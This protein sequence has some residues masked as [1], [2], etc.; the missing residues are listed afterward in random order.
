M[1][2]SPPEQGTADGGGTHAHRLTCGIDLPATLRAPAAARRAARTV[3]LAWGCTDPTTH[4]VVELVVT[5]LV[6][7]AVRYA[8]G[9]QPPRLHLE[10]G[11]E[12]L[13]AVSDGSS[14]PLVVHEFT[15]SAES[16]RGLGIVRSLAIT[17]GIEDRGPGKRVW[18]RIPTSPGPGGA[19]VPAARPAGRA[20]EPSPG[21]GADAVPTA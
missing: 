21:G 18:V 19:P 11:E 7:N 10:H 6:T 13:V 1:D 16:G 20:P 14:I 5:E 3:L 15:D 8:D 2:T 4:D 12:L 17:W 9:S